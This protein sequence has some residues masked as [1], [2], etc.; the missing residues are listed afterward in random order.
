[1]RQGLS[2]KRFLVE[3]ESGHRSKP[4]GHGCAPDAEA[5]K[6]KTNLKL[7]GFSD[8]RSLRFFLLLLRNASN[9]GSSRG[10]ERQPIA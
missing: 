7:A 6:D 2:F 1:M 3:L 10:S 5:R 4:I 8:D 9:A